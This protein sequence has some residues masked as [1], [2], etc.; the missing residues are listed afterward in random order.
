MASYAA[1]VETGARVP[2]AL[3]VRCRGRSGTLEILPN[4]D[5]SF[6]PAMV[7]GLMISIRP[8]VAPCRLWRQDGR[9][10][11]GRAHQMGKASTVCVPAP[12]RNPSL[13]DAAQA[14]ERHQLYDGMSHAFH[15]VFTLP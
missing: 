9:A 4:G 2:Q 8:I 1:D 3:S 11:D 14:L 10:G 12:F 6:K 5:V 13:A 15:A 7:R